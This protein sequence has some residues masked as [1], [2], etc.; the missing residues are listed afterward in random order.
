MFNSLPWE[1]VED[2]KTLRNKLWHFSQAF[3]ERQGIITRIQTV[4]N[5]LVLSTL[6]FMNLIIKLSAYMYISN[7]IYYKARMSKCIVSEKPL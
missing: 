6:A 4:H 1:Q 3:R 7:L 5:L 2:G